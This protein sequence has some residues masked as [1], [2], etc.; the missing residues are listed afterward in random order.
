MNRC[1]GKISNEIFWRWR[2]LPIIIHY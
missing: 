2:T 1:E